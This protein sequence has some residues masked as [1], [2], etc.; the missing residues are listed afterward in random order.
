[1]TDKKHQFSC[2][3]GIFDEVVN[4]QFGLIICGTQR[5]LISLTIN[6]LN[7][8]HISAMAEGSLLISEYPSHPFHLT[9]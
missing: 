4:L 6:C 9:L 8:V 1:M 5:T 3:D 7:Y 2:A